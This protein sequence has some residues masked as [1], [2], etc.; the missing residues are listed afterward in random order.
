MD[1]PKPQART[2][3]IEARKQRKLSQQ[4]V[5]ERIGTNY[6]NVS[7][8]ERGIT[9]PGPYFQRKL[10]RL[11]GKTEEELD[12]ALSSDVVPA[13]AHS[14]P[15]NAIPNT[16]A[17][18][19]QS[20][21]IPVSIPSST[22]SEAIYDPSIPLPPPVHLVGREEELANLRARLR[23]GENVAMTALH[24]LPGVGKTTLAITLAH[25]MEIRA[26]FRDGILWA[27]LGPRPDI[28]SI[29]SHWSLLLG[30]ATP[31]KSGESDHEALAVQLRRA[32]GTRR[33]LLVIDDAWKL[34]DA[35]VFKVGGP[36]CGHLVTTRFPGIAS[37]FA[38][39]STS[40]IHELD[41][42]KSMLLLH[43]LAPR[44]VEREQRKAEELAQA[45]GGLPLALTLLGNYL[46]Q[47]SG[48]PE[49]RIDAALA[50][51]SDA[52]GRL[53]ISEP[54]GPTERHSS[55]DRNIPLS[56]QAVIDVT[57]QQLH[58]QERKALF[59]LSVLP[60]RPGHF[61]EAAAL[62]VA[63]CQVAMLDRLMDM[64]LLEYTDTNHYT[65][66]QTIADYARTA[67]QNDAAP[68]ERLITYAMNL[69]EKHRKEYEILEPEYDTIIAALAS[70]RT[71][72][73]TK[74]MMR[75]TYAFIPYLRSRGL[76]E[77]AEKQLQRA[78]DSAESLGDTDS[79]SQA[80][81][82]R[83][84]I[85]QKRGNYEQAE[86]FLQDGLQLA[87]QIGNPERI[88]AL[89][90]DLG[91]I[92][93][94]R[95]EYSRAEIY[96]KE[97]LT[98][99]RQIDETE[100]ICDILETLGSVAAS[101]GQYNKSKEYLEE[102]LKLARSIGDREK[103]CTLLINLGVTAGEQD[104]F[105]HEERYYLEGL[106]IARELRHREWICALLSNL[107]ATAWAQEKYNS[108]E[109]Y[110]QD[111][112]T[113]ARQLEHRE[114]ISVLLVNLATTLRKQGRYAEAEAHLIEA[115]NTARQLGIPQIT[116]NILNEFGNLSLSQRYL[117]AAESY[118]NEVLV[119]ASEE[120]RDEVALAMYGLAQIA[121]FRGTIN[122]AQRL[123]E[124]SLSRLES[125]GHRSTSEVRNWLETLAG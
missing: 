35:L 56:L 32:I 63:D 14:S 13:T 25:D 53:H 86:A 98:L 111:G 101:R 93:S 122:E 20:E 62:A 71:I 30:V 109:S 2:K 66:H 89:L 55:L 11:F 112:L 97:G 49:R 120:D 99:A 83:G 115:L 43:M 40:I 108:A 94:K 51:L 19:A 91:W 74:E 39:T 9:R 116:C 44:V 27:A 105:V 106:Q 12:L 84:E 75:C 42:E 31:D 80:L 16:P 4:Q 60:V 79:K 90:A 15:A 68:H 10:S 17:F 1:A 123:G 76:Y 7:R 87:R 92:T 8:W 78:Y 3:L 113:Q 64:G 50:R 45:V 18:P 5:A 28:S 103:I 38:P 117:K 33:M 34:K 104:D 22:V 26:H 121:A 67:L 114:W 70:A 125:M 118:F 81:L 77:Q 88:S 54:R 57:C 85:A 102:A 6:V 24:G 119:V 52:E 48:G 21:S 58:P 65:L 95:S 69:V 46:H 61:S 29:L 124:D 59:A 73:K 37:A 47:Q 23:A 96:L 110:F 100:L 82:Y 36:N 107:G 41:T 72:G